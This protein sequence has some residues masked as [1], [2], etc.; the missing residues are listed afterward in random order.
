MWS[1]PTH[2]LYSES[3]SLGLSC[4]LPPPPG[5]FSFLLPVDLPA[6][7]LVKPWLSGRSGEIGQDISEK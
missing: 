7:V 2:L 1:I 3:C 4:R 6:I 5:S